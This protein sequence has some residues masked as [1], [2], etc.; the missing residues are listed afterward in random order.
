MNSGSRLL[1]TGAA[2]RTDFN[3]GSWPKIA[4]AFLG[5]A[6]LPAVLKVL[7]HAELSWFLLG[8]VVAVKV[9]LSVLAIVLSNHPGRV[10]R[11]VSS[12]YTISLGVVV[13]TGIL[14][15]PYSAYGFW[16]ESVLDGDP[17]G[18]VSTLIVLL[19]V[20]LCSSIARFILSSP[21]LLPVYGELLVAVSLLALI[22]QARFLYIAV[23]GLL[24]AGPAVL[25][26]RFVARG[27]RLRNTAVFL[28]LYFV[29]VGGAW[30][31][32]HSAEPRGSR[33]VNNQLHPG[34]RQIV[35]TLFPRF[36]LVYGI[37]GFGYGFSEK[38]LGGTPL[39]SEAPI[40]ETEG[41][42][43]ERLYL[44]T[45]V[46]DR[47]NGS[48]WSRSEQFSP[49]VVDSLVLQPL[50]ATD[51]FDAFIRIAVLV[52]YY[53]L[54][55]HT[56]NTRAVLIPAERLEDMSGSSSTSFELS[57]P[58]RRGDTIYLQNEQDLPAT[59]NS[60]RQP[61]RAPPADVEPYLQLP[62]RIPDRI[63]ELARSLADAGGGTRQ[64]LR[65][66]ERYLAANYS[67]NLKAKQSRS[68]E[69]FVEGFL[70]YSREGYCVHF[71]SAFILLAR[72]NG[73]PARY[74]TGFLVPLP[75]DTRVSGKTIVTG[76]NSHAWPEIWIEDSGWVTWEATTAVNPSYYNVYGDSWMYNLGWERNRLTRRQLRTILGKEPISASTGR[77]ATRSFPRQLIVP[78]AAIIAAIILLIFLSRRYGFLLFAALY[79]NRLSALKL[80][81]RILNSR[82]GKGIDSP[83]RVG[84]VCWIGEVERIL[85]R[86]SKTLRRLLLIIQRLVYSDD[87]L[88]IRDLRYLQAFYLRYC[89]GR[90]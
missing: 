58:L 32:L 44:R 45:E 84:W 23:I 13:L 62:E 78:L 82:L 74:A 3:R 83:Q 10:F 19:A 85:P 25:S 43:A 57:N 49:A 29:L 50:E 34:L 77:P 16:F 2:D 37:P 1:S 18:V 52:E 17:H 51:S 6:L 11:F 61:L 81:S 4:I 48:S 40:F 86:A 64:T 20:L 38:R 60:L 12:L 90:I 63:G 24:A 26:L 59:G 53:N 39:L 5:A 71:T 89:R 54:V 87:A 42:P 79:P 56:L 14:I 31:L 69:D 55:P 28:L 72:L 46:F 41:R 47:Y 68:S 88:R 21:P 66:I 22:Y 80:L 65:N 36:P 30:L 15:T 67:Y 33:I 75:T 76:L 27:N 7:V 9:V 35:I 8:G 73:I 70:F